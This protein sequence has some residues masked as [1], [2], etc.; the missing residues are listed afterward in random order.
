MVKNQL[1]TIGVMLPILYFGL[2]F[3][4]DPCTDPLAGIQKVTFSDAIPRL[5][6]STLRSDVYQ[7][8]RGPQ[9]LSP[10]RPA[11]IITVGGEDQFLAVDARFV[12]Q[13]GVEAFLKKL[14]DDDL[15]VAHK[16]WI[17]RVEDKF[18]L[19]EHESLDVRGFA[20]LWDSSQYLLELDVIKK[21]FF[22]Q[23]F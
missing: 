9:K 6:A 19:Y 7:L 14:V 11:V 5:T 12:Y 22:S 1:I 13:I 20:S 17:A 2:A 21:V 4:S 15:R 18:A 10:V 3:A 23:I 8:I 16:D